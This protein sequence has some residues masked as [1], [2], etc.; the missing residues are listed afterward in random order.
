[1]ES[2]ASRPWGS[3]LSWFFVFS[4]VVG[5]LTSCFLILLYT[6]Q[7]NFL[8]IPRPPGFPVDPEDN[9]RGCRSPREWTRSGKLLSAHELASPDS[10][11]FDD[12]TVETADGERLHVWLLYQPPKPH[13]GDQA[14]NDSST[15]SPTIIYFHGNAGIPFHHLLLHLTLCSSQHGL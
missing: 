7:D 5:G 11:P 8:Y 1:M 4:G 9:P 14:M 6:Y 3:V 15:T 10:I 13:V 12:A 2:V